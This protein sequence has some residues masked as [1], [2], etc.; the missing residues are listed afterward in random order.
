MP[1]Q[2]RGQELVGNQNGH[3]RSHAPLPI[4]SSTWGRTTR[5]W[6]IICAQ[7]MC[8]GW[9]MLLRY[10]S[11]PWKGLHFLLPVLDRLAPEPHV[12]LFPWPSPHAD[13]YTFNEYFLSKYFLSDAARYQGYKE[14]QEHTCVLSSWNWAK[15]LATILCWFWDR[16]GAGEQ[17]LDLGGHQLTGPS[18]H[19]LKKKIQIT[20]NQK[21]CQLPFPESEHGREGVWGLSS[22]QAYLLTQDSIMSLA[23]SFSRCSKCFPNSSSGQCKSRMKVWR[24]SS[25]QNRSS[26]VPDPLLAG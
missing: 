25:F 17:E 14:E 15:T 16:C 21:R 22:R 1:W 11:H 24:A 3:L 9:M 6:H 20:A 23:I 8:M 5:S 10:C 12:L 4:S 13:T 7:F 2:Y 19:L 26:E 18:N